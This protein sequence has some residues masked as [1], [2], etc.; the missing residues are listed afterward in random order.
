MKNE[1]SAILYTHGKYEKIFV[2]NKK[3]HLLTSLQGEISTLVILDREVRADFVFTVQAMDNGHTPLSGY[4][5][6]RKQSGDV[7][8]VDNLCF[9]S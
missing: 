6:V 4:T 3:W 9:K 7:P 8:T 2:S 5:S 1:I